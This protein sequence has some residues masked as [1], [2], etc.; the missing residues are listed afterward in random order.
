MKTSRFFLAL[1]IIA[2]AVTAA[3][4]IFSDSAV[5]VSVSTVKKE[6]WAPYLFFSGTV[7]NSDYVMVS[8]ADA[9]ISEV[10]VKKGDNVTEGQPLCSIDRRATAA[11]GALSGNTVASET[12]I[13]AEKSGKVLSVDVESGGVVEEGDSLITLDG[14]G[15]MKVTVLVGESNISDIKKGQKAIITG[16][17]FK[18]RSYNAVVTTIGSS[19]K[20]VTS[21]STK[22]VVVE[23]GLAIEN[24][25]EALKSGFTAKVKIFTDEETEITVL[26]YSAVLQ[27]DAGEY[28]YIY[29]QGKAVRADVKT[30]R[31]L[32]NGYEVL[33]GIKAGDK[34]ITSPSAIKKSGTSVIIKGRE[35]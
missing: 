30:G 27:D 13:L 14:D 32:E 17:G 28:V 7:E 16:N 1:I 26:P 10:F 35:V 21:G 33:S 6:N 9:V 11:M 20:K 18:D 12:R 5:S 23:V 4:N 25:D 22:I 19:A 3:V 31:E 15:G 34:V 2:A 24:P 8:E 29:K